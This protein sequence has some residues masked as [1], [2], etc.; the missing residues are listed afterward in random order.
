KASPIGRE[1]DSLASVTGALSVESN[2]LQ[3]RVDEYE[4][5]HENR[6]YFQKT[7]GGHSEKPNDCAMRKEAEQRSLP[8]RHNQRTG[9]ITA[10]KTDER[11]IIDPK[12]QSVATATKD[13]VTVQSDK[14]ANS[15][16]IAA[17][18]Q[19]NVSV[20]TTAT[21][22][23]SLLNAAKTVNNEVRNAQNATVAAA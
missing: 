13:T 19:T 23:D 8:R 20:Q 17:Q 11:K 21:Q 4:F 9:D 1:V 16:T 10:L 12:A 18:L 2:R 14:S 3:I 7:K 22:S 15:E 5:L 6:V